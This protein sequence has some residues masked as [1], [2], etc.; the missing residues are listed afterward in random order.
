MVSLSI[1]SPVYN[2]GKMVQELVRRLAETADKIT[3]KFEVILVD[4]GSSDS[5]WDSIISVARQYSFVKGLK[6]SRNFGQHAAIAAGLQQSSGEWVVVMDSDLQEPPEIISALFDMARQ[7]YHVVLAKR[8]F[9]TDSLYRRLSSRFFHAL[10]SWMS[11]FPADHT[12]ANFGIYSR[13]VIDTINSLEESHRFFP[14]MI[15]WVGFSKTTVEYDHGARPEGSSGYNFRKLS[16]LA[17]TIILSYSDKPLRYV[18]KL[19]LIISLATF[20]YGIITLVRY[21]LGDISVLG[22]T[23]LILSIWFLGGLILF[24]LGIV[25]LYLGKTF[26]EVKKRPLFVVEKTLNG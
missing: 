18:V 3:D 10:L 17:L 6:L 25:G 1:V 16:R 23:S 2:T 4:D 14:M 15:H 19:G 7:G 11:G 5:S 13:Q 24:T 21:F 8:R 22:Y 12:I 26:E 9:R 20:I